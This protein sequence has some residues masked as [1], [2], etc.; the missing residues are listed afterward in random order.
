MCTVHVRTELTKA[1]EQQQRDEDKIPLAPY[2]PKTHI[3]RLK[4]KK[5]LMPSEIP[6]GAGAAS[7]T[8]WGK[9]ENKSEIIIVDAD[10]PA[11]QQSMILQAAVEELGGDIIAAKESKQIASGEGAF[12]ASL[13]YKGI[14]TTANVGDVRAMLLFRNKGEAN[15]ECLRLSCDHKH[16]NVDKEEQ[17]RCREAKFSTLMT[18][19]DN[20]RSGI[21][22]LTRELGAE[23]SGVTYTPTMT[24]Y[25]IPAEVQEA[26]LITVTEL[27]SLMQEK[28]IAQFVNE[29]DVGSSENPS[30]F[31]AD[32]LSTEAADR[33]CENEVSILVVDVAQRIN[34]L[35][36]PVVCFIANQKDGA[37]SI[38]SY[39]KTHFK[40][41]FDNLLLQYNVPKKVIED[42]KQEQ[43]I[44]PKVS[45]NM[46][47][48]HHRP[49]ATN[50]NNN[51]PVK[52]YNNSGSCSIC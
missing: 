44:T 47:T 30:Q 12:N 7:M 14:I 46:S 52:V 51:K 27:T 43:E 31:I 40:A 15:F 23:I 22:V 17:E 25:E 45:D 1:L 29:S 28:H 50:S 37:D 8:T 21:F 42:K 16:E 4:N 19:R 18:D 5:E 38:S 10:I 39:C 20:Y 13:I 41:I 3:K 24:T 2:N 49:R 33:G 36:L 9:E 48:L 34:D 26:Y 32:L 11:H 35:S 6:T